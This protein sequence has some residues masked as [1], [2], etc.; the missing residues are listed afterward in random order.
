[1]DI[2]LQTKVAD[3]LKN[4]PELETKLLELSPAFAKL[5]NP[6]LRRTV[7]KITS[8]QQAA[9]V[10]GIP[11]A[12]MVQELR[13]AVGLSTIDVQD[14]EDSGNEKSEPPYWFDKEKIRA[15]FDACPVIESGQSPMQE[16]LDLAKG[17]SKDEILQ[18]ITPFK[19]VPIIDKLKSRGFTVWIQD[20]NNYFT[21][22]NKERE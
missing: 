19:P 1:M 11:P 3:L 21:L 6:I 13:K 17:L 20:N 16:I 9:G 12:L 7:A 5:K 10:A 14:I 18:I 2:T 15:I 8:L 4:Y 22:L